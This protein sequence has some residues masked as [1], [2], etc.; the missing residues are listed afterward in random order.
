MKQGGPMRG[1]GVATPGSTVPVEV[2]GIGSVVVT[3][4]GGT[5]IQVP[6]R[7]GKVAVPVPANAPLGS[8]LHV[9]LLGRLPPVG[10]SIT[11]VAK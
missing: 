1:P 8:Q 5:L 2:D 10:L 11:V 4:P 3:Q 9:I 7:D 6:V